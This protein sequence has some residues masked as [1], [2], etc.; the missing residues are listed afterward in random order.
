MVAQ[1]SDLRSPQVAPT[2]RP[3][4]NPNQ[5]LPD[6]YRARLSLALATIG[7]TVSGRISQVASKHRAEDRQQGAEAVRRGD[8]VSNRPQE[9]G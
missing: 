7:A 8:V 5:A 4:R 1:E 3:H 9:L 6:R 2:V